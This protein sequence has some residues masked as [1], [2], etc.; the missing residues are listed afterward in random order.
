[1][2]ETLY[3]ALEEAWEEE[4]GKE[5]NSKLKNL[6]VRVTEKDHEEL[7]RVAEVYAVSVSQVVRGILRSYWSV[8]E[9]WSKA[10]T[11]G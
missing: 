3:E 6:S 1:M 2:A 11:T 4:F 8:R 5:T 10:K 7:K 9:Y